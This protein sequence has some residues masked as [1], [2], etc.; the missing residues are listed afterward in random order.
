MSSPLPSPVKLAYSH[1][2]ETPVDIL[3]QL[4]EDALSLGV[5]CFFT[6]Q[7]IALKIH[8]GTSLRNAFVARHN[9]HLV[10]HGQDAFKYRLSL[11]AIVTPY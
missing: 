8:A 4:S 6:S 7:G 1:K 3:T 10:W 9:S 11:E 5:T 2:S